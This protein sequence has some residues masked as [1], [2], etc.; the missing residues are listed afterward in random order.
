MASKIKIKKVFFFIF[1]IAILALGI[2]FYIGI[3]HTE[4][5]KEYNLF[6]LIPSDA[7][8][9]FSPK[10]KLFFLE[11]ISKEE[12]ANE[13]KN[14]KS[15]S[16]LLEV[17]N[18][19]FT[20]L[21][22][23][24]QG[25][26]KESV[27][28]I[29]ISF[30]EPYGIYDQ[31]LYCKLNKKKFNVFRKFVKDKVAGSFPHKIFVYKGEEIRIYTLDSGEFIA[32]YVTPNFFAVSFQKKLLEK[33]ID[34]NIEG[35]SL[36]NDSSFYAH[37]MESLNNGPSL[38]L[39]LDDVHFNNGAIASKNIADWISFNLKFTNQEIVFE[40]VSSLDDAEQ[41]YFSRVLSLQHQTPQPSSKWLPSTTSYFL[42]YSL[43]NIQAVFD[44]A[45]DC[46]S[47][48][49]VMGDTLDLVSRKENTLQIQEFLAQR[50]KDYLFLL[51]F[52]DSLGSDSCNALLSFQMDPLRRNEQELRNLY[53]DLRK[54]D[55]SLPARDYKRIKGKLYTLYP[56]PVN[57]VMNQFTTSRDTI[58]Y[59]YATL[60]NDHLLLASD[61]QSLVSYIHFIE[62][63][64]TLPLKSDHALL[65][66][67]DQQLSGYLKFDQ[68]LN[69]SCYKGFA[70]PSVFFT[71]AD[72]FSDYE[73]RF[74]FIVNQ[75]E[76]F[77]NLNLFSSSKRGPK[78][79]ILN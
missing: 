65:M 25:K 10:D 22:P 40:G 7:K 45:S 38:Y 47:K 56:L 66:N 31:V 39:K 28:N 12:P 27:D 8:I 63:G 67:E 13:D 64:D 46:L 5:E 49:D 42:H 44:Y 77:V 75:K 20:S 78:P 19:F 29:L 6:S 59:D 11:E 37:G 21:T 73:L 68:L 32:F 3:S 24:L 55:R 18:D 35:T 16:K 71:Y 70:L 60:Y 51:Q 34:A 69:F 53:Y 41:S 79:S 76:L 1:L 9:V 58:P 30:H 17:V 54:K 57:D 74:Q 36:L 72:F 50:V 33:V 61:R 48:R 15:K 43:S 23:N 4:Y 52:K 62:S 14:R 2:F 26:T